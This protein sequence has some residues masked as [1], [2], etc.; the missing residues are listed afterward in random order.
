MTEKN[1]LHVEDLLLERNKL[2][3]AA[4]KRQRRL[5]HFLISKGVYRWGR[6][7]DWTNQIVRDV[8]KEFDWS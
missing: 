2:R 4:R 8:C 1:K 5:I 7:L 3:D 6:P